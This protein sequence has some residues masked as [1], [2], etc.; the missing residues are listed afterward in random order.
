MARQALICPTATWISAM[1]GV[2]V[3]VLAGCSSTTAPERVLIPISQIVVPDSVG[4][5]SALSVDV[6]VDYGGCAGSAVVGFTGVSFSRAPDHVT[7]AAWGARSTKTDVACPDYGRTSTVHL[8]VP[9]PWAG[10]VTI[11]AEQPAT[12][13]AIVHH[14]QVR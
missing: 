7:V 8:D 10:S 4:Q 9:G 11:S 12:A 1:L 13:P 6:T 3:A 5:D 2:T 14:V